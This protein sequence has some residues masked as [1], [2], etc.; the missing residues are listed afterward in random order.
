MGLSGVCITDHETQA[1]YTQAQALSKE[2]G[3]LVIV[4][5]E[6]SCHEGHLLVYGVP[7]LKRSQL[8]LGKILKEIK[9]LG[10]IAIAA[11]PFRW[12]SPNMGDAIR[13]YADE[14]D[15]I[16]AFNGGATTEE[17]LLAY[18]FAVENGLPVFGGSDAH[19]ETRVGKF[20]T[21]FLTPIKDEMD[22]I[23]SIIRAKSMKNGLDSISVAARKG[24]S[25]VPAY[26]YEKQMHDRVSPPQVHSIKDVLNAT[27][28]RFSV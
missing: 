12:D 8:P 26:S 7:E 18:E 11:H 19:H 2:S 20:V 22:F 6:Y 1:L 5:L 9:S 14:L 13:E 21:N 16:E 10:G 25:F 17:N 3:L 24:T 28:N 23:K 4:G 15:G 27:K